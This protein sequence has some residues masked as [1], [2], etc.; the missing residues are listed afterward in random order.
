MS[1]NPKIVAILLMLV[2]DAIWLTLMNPRYG[3]L[4]KSVQGSPMQTRLV[5]AIIAYIL[6]IVGLLYIVLENIKKDSSNNIIWLSFKYGFLFG[7]VV[8]G[9]FNSTNLAIFKG[10]S[11]TMAVADTLWGSFLFFFVTYVTLLLMR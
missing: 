5:P 11:W 3:E 6:M 8:Y 9:I 10:Y 7:F 2:L 4:I 1:L